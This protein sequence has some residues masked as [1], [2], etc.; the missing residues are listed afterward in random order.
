MKD[1]R[2]F[3]LVDTMVGLAI[4]GTVASALLSGLYSGTRGTMI[5]QERT[6]AESLVR[7]EIEY[8]KTYTYQPVP[9]SYPLDPTLTLPPGWSIPNPASQL[10][11]TNDD[12]MQKITVSA[13]HNGKTVLSVIMYKVNR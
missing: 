9:S 3:S 7:S 1:Q 12:G 13:Q 11:H 5:T 4:F 10:V 8:V 6:L 2:G